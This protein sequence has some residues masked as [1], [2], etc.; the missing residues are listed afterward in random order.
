MK[1]KQIL[2]FIFIAFAFW[3]FIF[4]PIT[5]EHVNFWLMMCI[6]D[7]VLLACV[8]IFGRD[9]KEDIHFNLLNV[10]ISV[11]I[12]GFLWLIFFIGD[13]VSCFLFPFADSQINNVYCIKSGFNE[14]IIALILF[15]FVGP[16]EELF[17]RG[18]VQRQLNK[19]Y[20][21][22]KAMLITLLFYVSIH[23]AS[24]NFMLIMAALVAGLCWGLIYRFFPKYFL[25][26][27]LSHAIWDACV[28]IIFPI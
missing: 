4:S 5:K 27:I 23:I 6:A 8:L 20:T 1:L 15:L 7:T 22:T 10:F 21:P 25:A 28:F 13:K 19:K 14:K 18:F 16:V 12:A 17:W 11:L 9:V 2:I 24:L 3:F 26:S